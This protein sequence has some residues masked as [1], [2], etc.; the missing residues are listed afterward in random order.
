MEAATNERAANL[1]THT[2]FVEE[3]EDAIDAIDECLALL[4]SLNS[5]AASLI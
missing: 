4:D 5:G 3:C 1:N 2:A